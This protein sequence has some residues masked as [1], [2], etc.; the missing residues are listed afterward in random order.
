M[1]RP[2]SEAMRPGKWQKR[3]CCV[4]SYPLNGVKGVF[5]LSVVSVLLS[6]NVV[7]ALVDTGCS[8]TVVRAQVVENCE[9][10]CRMT[11]FDGR[12]FKCQ[13]VCW[14]DLV[15]VEMPLKV[16]AIVSDKIISAGIDEV[17]GM[18]VIEWLGASW[19]AEGKCNLKLDC[20]WQPVYQSVKP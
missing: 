1:E 15:V 18:D 5:F 11:A 16:H 7:R 9:G 17:M 19:I 12:E 8:T 13:G 6:V 20:V 4:S 2:Y 10:E 14:V 3:G